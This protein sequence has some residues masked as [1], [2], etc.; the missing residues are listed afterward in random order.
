M[1]NPPQHPPW[2]WSSPGPPAADRK[3]PQFG[4]SFSEALFFRKVSS[5][6]CLRGQNQRWALLCPA[7]LSLVR[8]LRLSAAESCSCSVLL[9]VTVPDL[10]R[11][12]LCAGGLLLGRHD[13]ML[14]WVREN[15]AP[16][17]QFWLWGQLMSLVR[18]SASTR[19]QQQARSSCIRGIRFSSIDGRA[20]L[21]NLSVYTVMILLGFII[22]ST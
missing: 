21:Q 12:F 11:P 13:L 22:N 15:P 2:P 8:V 4:N 20:L 10:G 1:S 14:S 3:S 9:A 6:L 7:N 16:A 5:H 19:A 17:G 18:P